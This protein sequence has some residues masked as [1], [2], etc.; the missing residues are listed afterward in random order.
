MDTVTTILVTIITLL[1]LAAFLSIA[2]G[3]ISASRS[4]SNSQGSNDG[5]TRKEK[6]YPARRSPYR[7]TSIMNKGN[8]CSAVKNLLNFRFLD[9]DNVLSSIPVSGCNVGHCNCAYVQHADRRDHKGD[10]RALHS[11]LTDLYES[12]GKANRRVTARGRRKRDLSRLN[13][14]Y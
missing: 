8:K 7:A 4:S 13:V 12:P 6:V 2:L 3:N 10:R 11:L 5:S 1:I 14:Q 9:L